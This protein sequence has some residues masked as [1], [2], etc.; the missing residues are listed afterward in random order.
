M[1]AP[2]PDPVAPS[3]VVPSDVAAAALDPSVDATDEL[4]S[5]QR[6][7]RQRRGFR[8]GLSGIVLAALG[9]RVYYVLVVTR[10][11]NSKFYDAAY[12]LLQS[13]EL[14][15]GHFFRVFFGRGPDASH[16][17]LTSLVIT[18]ATYFYGLPPGF[19]PQRLTMAGLGALVVLVVGLLGRR[20]AG[21]G[22]GLLAA[23]AAAVYPNMWI[24]NGIIMSE[25]LTMLVMAVI[26]LALYRLRV[27]PTW[28]NALLLGLACGVEILVRAELVLLVP[29]LLLP[30]V[31]LCRQVSWRRRA[32]LAALGVVA[33]G[34][35]VGPWVGRNLAT[36]EDTTTFSTGQGG[37]LLGANCPQTYSG[38]GLG[39]WSLTC[40]IDVPPITKTQDQ[41]VESTRAYNAAKTYIRHH[42]GRLPL[43]ALARVG[44]VWDFY[45]PLQMV[46]VDVN[47]G[48]PVPTAFA[49]LLA[50]WVLLPFALAG[51]VVLRRRRV[52]VW[53]LVVIAGLVTVIAAAGY[54]QI[55]FRAEFEV[56][57]VVLA[58]VGIS[59]LRPRRRRR[60]PVPQHAGPLL[61]A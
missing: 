15:T 61:E 21:P 58:A 12:Y 36:F 45:E 23:A 54:G 29:F 1:M 8:V 59:A 35:V 56:V 26:L 22:V 48:R 32:A 44:R 40:A 20:L 49:G 31:A 11:E 42:L 3:T 27:A 41:S 7:R 50:Y 39:S 14:S 60:Q 37:L 5:A 13:L 24:P 47:E 38:P 46:D 57:L 53:P 28:A 2:V 16:P 17:P 51:V 6:A 55:R 10:H 25:T 9:I 52:A 30:A 4:V 19:T 18:P 33:A 34:L 43:V